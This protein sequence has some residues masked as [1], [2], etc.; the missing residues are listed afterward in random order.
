MMKNPKTFLALMLVLSV[1]LTPASLYAGDGENMGYLARG[2]G[3]IFG[4]M[5]AIP[6]AMLQDSGRVLFPLGLVTGA[7]RG[8]VQTVTG[9]VGGVV[10]VARGGAPYAQYAALAL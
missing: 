2:A 8:T 1:L 7:V 4:S 3:R 6:K 5:F 10:D 9:V